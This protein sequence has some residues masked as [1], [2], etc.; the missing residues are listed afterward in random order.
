MEELNTLFRT[1]LLNRGHYYN[2]TNNGSRV[3]LYNFVYDTLSDKAQIQCFA[4]SDALHPARYTIPVGATWVKPYGTIVPVIRILNNV[5]QT[6]LG[7]SAGYYPPADISNP[8]AKGQLQPVS[9][10]LHQMMGMLPIF[11][12]LDLVPV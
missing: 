12:H 11:T 6:I 1:T 3:F 8:S 2:D 9:R 7:I 5:F 10:L 4:T